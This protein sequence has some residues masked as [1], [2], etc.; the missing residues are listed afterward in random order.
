VDRFEL[1]LQDYS[2]SED[3]ESVR[4][5][6]SQF[7][8]KECPST[9]VRAAEPLG[10]D[11]QLWHRLVDMG[12]TSMSLPAA[13]GGDEATLVDLTLI[14][15]EL[16]RTVAPVPFI[17]HV[18]ATRLLAAAGTDAELIQ[19]A[20]AGDRPFAVALQPLRP[21]EAQLVPDAAVAGDVIAL[22]ADALVLT[23]A[24]KASPHLLNQGSTPLGWWQ[25]PA[26]AG[27]IV[28]AE[29]TTALALHA[30]AVREW[31][32]LTAAALI[33]MT[34]A[35]LA[36]AVEFAKTRE[37]MGVPIGSLQGVA[38]P[39]ADVAIGVSGGR[40]VI[41]RAAWM[42]ENE[43]GVRPEL[44]PIAYANATRVATHGTTTSAHM[45]GGLGFTI[46]ADASLYFLRAKGWS[47]LGGDPNLDLITVGDAVLA[48]AAR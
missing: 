48:S 27:R 1:R 42:A 44:V 41:W 30:R 6:F 3:Q 35:A 40:N 9:V 16:G 33:G 17:S 39:L 15:E 26:G 38:F 18:V 19:A 45:Q 11:K 21:G 32:L 25:P 23:S 22:E 29:G 14:A 13:L 34:E 4:D 47:V 43:P 2:L 10:Y 8:A 7:F 5:A 12:V 37:T 31:K 24:D 20:V 36:L 46:E 28:L